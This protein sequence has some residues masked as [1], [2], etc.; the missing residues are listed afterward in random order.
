MTYKQ[1][2]LHPGDIIGNYK[3]IDKIGK[4]GF[5]HT[6]SAIKN[7]GDKNYL[8][9]IKMVEKN[10]I[11]DF[12]EEKIS[13]KIKKKMKEDKKEIYNLNIYEEVIKSDSDYMYFISKKFNGGNLREFIA[14]YKE[15][16]TIEMIKHVMKQVLFGLE[17]L[18]SIDIIHRDL[19]P[20]NLMIDY[21]DIN[22]KD[23]LKSKIIII[24]YG[25]G[26]I[27]QQEKEESEDTNNR[28]TLNYKHHKIIQ[29]KFLNQ[30]IKIDL[31]VEL[32]IWS[33]GLI[34]LELF[35]GKQ[36]YNFKAQ[37]E[38]DD[39]KIINKELAIKNTYLIPYNKYSTIDLVESIDNMLQ[40]EPKNQIKLK[41]IS[42]LDFLNY[43]EDN[44]KQFSE[45]NL[46]NKLKDI[47][48]KDGKKE[49]WIE[50]NFENGLNFDYDYLK[51]KKINNE[52]EKLI[53]EC[54]TLLNIKTLFTEQVLI[55][56]IENE[57]E[58]EK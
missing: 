7:N 34:C 13:E 45:E 20:E 8:Y 42:K 18:N 51:N 39:N 17:T 40:S 24:D 31:N 30:K 9:C 32:D 52:K 29:K 50:L 28:G 26:K 16:F 21:E 37:N 41:D 56:I 23:F 43:N 44:F 6:Y 33:L 11:G 38:K 5:G 47:D 48:N 14:K 1:K 57:N 58:D 4:G 15:P 12:Q 27:I 46:G 49:K 3:V 25:C 55:P 22:N 36:L 2:E 10:E 35:T 54:F 53:K 19:K